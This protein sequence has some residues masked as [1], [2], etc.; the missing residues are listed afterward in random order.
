MMNVIVPA[1]SVDV[2]LTP[3]KTQVMLQDKVFIMFWI[4]WCNSDA[5]YWSTVF[6]CRSFQDAVLLAVESVLI[7][8]YGSYSVGNDKQTMG[9]GP[10]AAAQ[11]HQLPAAESRKEPLRVSEGVAAEP[12]LDSRVMAPPVTLNHSTTDT[13]DQIS[14][15]SLPSTANTS[16]SSSSEDWIINKSSSDFDGVN[17]SLFA[18]NDALSSTVAPDQSSPSTSKDDADLGQGN[19]VSAESWAMG[20]AFTDQTTGQCLEPVKLHLPEAQR[21]DNGV[22]DPKSKSNSPSKRPSNVIMEKMAKLTAY[23][24]LSSRSVRQPLSAFALFEQDTRSSVLQENPRASLQ[25]VTAAVK[26]RWESLGEEG[27]KK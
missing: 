23:D 19:T 9:E 2:N 22:Q 21:D 7:S 5:L 16:S 26:E 18:E 25:D 14:E 4:K 11:N 10:S 3:D 6:L 12:S 17:F 1:S 20:R 13:K 8:L 15:A 24:L 27:R